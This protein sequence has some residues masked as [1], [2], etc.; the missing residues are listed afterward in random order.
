MFRCLKGDRGQ[1]FP[2]YITVVAG[3]LFL[4]FA[5]F[6]WGQASVKRNEAQTAADAAA[7]AA[8]Q[9]A[10]GNLRTDLLGVTD[11]QKLKDLVD[12]KI[13]SGTHSCDAATRLADTNGATLS[14]GAGCHAD[15]YRGDTAYFVKVESRKPVGKSV[16]AA[17]EDKKATASAVAVIQPRCRVEE[18]DTPSQSPGPGQD[19]GQDQGK[20]YKFVCDGRPDIPFDLAHLADLLPSAADLF[21]VHLVNVN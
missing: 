19:K 17:T 2:I 3:L 18:G 4:A 8:A 12:G 16:I 13:G 15:V 11:P 14:Q 20:G 10:R 1:A 21:S 7:L 5:Y 9:D 6:A